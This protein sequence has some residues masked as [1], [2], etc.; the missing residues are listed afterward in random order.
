VLKEVNNLWQ[1]VIEDRCRDYIYEL[2]SSDEAGEL[3]QL[4]KEL[5]AW[6]RNS[7]HVAEIFFQIDDEMR[8]A[9][10]DMDDSLLTGASDEVLAV[11]IGHWQ[12]ARINREAR[13]E[14]RKIALPAEGIEPT[15]SSLQN[16]R[17]TN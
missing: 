11:Y 5:A 17:S 13:T 15:T 10:S 2:E 3:Q 1:R 12:R 14:I 9:E 6:L 7:P 8:E 4:V 16:W